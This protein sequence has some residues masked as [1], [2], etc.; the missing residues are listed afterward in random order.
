[1]NFINSINITVNIIYSVFTNIYICWIAF[2][3]RAMNT[4]VGKRKS[5]LFDTIFLVMHFSNQI[6]CFWSQ[7]AKQQYFQ[8]RS[9]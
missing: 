4:H 7:N 9:A 2:A 6:A 8:R 1:M 5:D 3:L